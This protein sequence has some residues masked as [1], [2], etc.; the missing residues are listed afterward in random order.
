MPAS[1]RSR[2]LRSATLFAAITSGCLMPTESSGDYSVVIAPIGEIF[3]GESVQLDARLV[4]TGGKVVPV[5]RLEYASSD[6]TIALVSRDGRLVAAGAGTVEI[7]ARAAGLSQAAPG[8]AS[9]RVHGPVEIDSVRPLAV[10]YGET[11]RVH[12]V[13]LSPAGGQA[14]VRIDGHEAPIVGFTPVDAARPEAH[15]VL[16]VLLTP[17]V[18]V[19]QGDESGFAAI[20]AVVVVANARG[21]ASRIAPFTVEKRDRFEPNDTTSAD[22]GVITGPREVLGLAFDYA[23]AGARQYPVDWYTFTTTTPGDWTITVRSAQGSLRQPSVQVVTGPMTWLRSGNRAVYRIDDV[24]NNTLGMQGSCRGFAGALDDPRNW[25]GNEFFADYFS[26]AITSAWGEAAVVRLPLRNLP[27]GTH[28]LMI[29]AGGATL[30]T[31]PWGP[32]FTPGNFIS[33]VDPGFPTVEATQEAVRYDLRIAPGDPQPVMRDAFEPNDFCTDA[34]VLLTLG[35]T[36]FADS[37]ID[38]SHDAELDWDWFRIRGL[39]T[40]R[41]QVTTSSRTGKMAPRMRVYFPTPGMTGKVNR[42]TQQATTYLGELTSD[43]DYAPGLPVEV[44]DYYLVGAPSSGGDNLQG[45]PDTY[46]LTI[47]WEPGA[48]PERPAQSESRVRDLPASLRKVTRVAPGIK[49]PERR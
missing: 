32:G 21:G 38:L 39:V 47:S 14:A 25:P 44:K 18:G 45:Y 48:L 9:I 2:A 35:N 26:S 40:G 13:G 10:R 23:P 30:G 36:A 11:L 5:A 1:L 3:A 46:R 33:Y 20:Q 6:P 17:P 28:H 31:G 34:P 16:E 12:G 27:A 15:G 42:M 41:L 8:I 49:L 7:T 37:T 19:G 4:G 43:V 22:L 29:G 24:T